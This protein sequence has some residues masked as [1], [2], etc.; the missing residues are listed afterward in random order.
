MLRK[1]NKKNFLRRKSKKAVSLMVSYVLLISIAIFL[2]IA[3]YGSLKILSNV[4]PKVDCKPDTS[5]IVEEYSC[6]NENSFSITLRNNGNFNINGIILTVTGNLDKAPII[7]LDPAFGIG[8]TR[9]GYYV[10]SNDLKP[11]K[12]A[13]A[14]YSNKERGS[15]VQFDPIGSDSIVAI[16]I[17]PFILD[18]SANP[19][20]CEK[21]VIDQPIEPCKILPTSSTP[22]TSP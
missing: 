13:T 1:M 22:S 9:S 11:G 5:F 6:P 10:F 14:T 7:N 18:K 8:G 17:Q 21:A 19:L 16:R 3:V 12:T 20:I 4:S 15:L 2:A